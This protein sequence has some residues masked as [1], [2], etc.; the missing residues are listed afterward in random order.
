MPESTGAPKLMD[1]EMFTA[2]PVAASALGT[3][4][5]CRCA[6]CTRISF[7]RVGPSVETSWPPIENILSV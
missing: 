3:R 4:L 7:N 6:H 5:L 2:G 1:P